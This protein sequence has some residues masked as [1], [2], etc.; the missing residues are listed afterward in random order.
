MS[1]DVEKMIADATAKRP[2]TEHA[3]AIAGV[4]DDLVS[5]D[6]DLALKTYDR[7]LRADGRTA[8][9]WTGRATVL[10]KRSRAGEA[11]ACLDRALDAQPGYADAVVLKADIL[12]KLGQRVEAVAAFDEAL[13]K[14]PEEKRLWLDRAR[15]LDELAKPDEALASLDHAVANGD[16]AAAWI[17]RSDILFRV[18]RMEE[19]ATSLERALQADPERR[20]AWYAL[21]RAK[22]KLGLFSDARYAFE[23][24]NVLAG[25]SDPRAST[26]KR[27]AFELKDVPDAP[28]KRADAVITPASLPEVEPAAPKADEPKIAISAKPTLAEVDLSAIEELIKEKRWLEGLRKLEPL[29]KKHPEAVQVWV[30]RATA[31]AALGQVDA[32]MSSADRASRVDP[33]HVDAWKVLARAASAAK[34]DDRAIEA[35][36]KLRELAHED[37]EAHR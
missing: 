28:K 13:A 20:D 9:A 22:Q 2:R 7:A 33:N 5:Q 34:K 11:L 16:D 21:G 6:L 37:A 4:A 35:A 10:A 26:A 25:E 32:A 8:R 1:I 27:L 12:M 23:R 29:V 17:L 14:R 31:L 19:A 30:M 18:G 36:K 3:D 15:V 24:F